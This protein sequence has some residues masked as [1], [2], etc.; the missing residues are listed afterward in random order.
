MQGGL[1]VDNGNVVVSLDHRNARRL[2]LDYD[3]LPLVLGREASRMAGQPVV[4]EVKMLYTS[5]RP[6]TSDLRRRKAFLSA[7]HQKGWSVDERPAKLYPDGHWEEKGNDLAIA[8]DALGMAYRKYISAVAVV[9]DDADFAALFERLP[10]DVKGFA[11]GW[12]RTMARELRTGATPI[13]L[14][15]LMGELELAAPLEGKAT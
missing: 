9:S 15:G 10:L 7:M 4:F 2:R 6:D 1:F 5:Y 12:D 3:K 14:D 8:L 11:V 13:Y